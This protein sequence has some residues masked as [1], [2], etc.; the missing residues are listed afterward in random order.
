MV[1]KCVCLQ[2]QKNLTWNGGLCARMQ[3]SLHFSPMLQVNCLFFQAVGP[4][5]ALS[6]LDRTHTL[7]CDTISSWSDIISTLSQEINYC[8]KPKKI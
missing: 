4:A 6:T 5:L 3:T 7:I 2:L 8:S 1:T